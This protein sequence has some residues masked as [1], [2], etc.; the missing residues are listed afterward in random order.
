MEQSFERAYEILK[1]RCS[2]ISITKTNSAIEIIKGLNLD[3]DSIV[4]AC[5]YIPFTHNH[6]E[7]QEVEELFGEGVYQMV[8]AL[9]Q[10]HKIQYNNEQEEAENIRKMYFALAKDIRVIFIKLAFEVADMR[11][12]QLFKAD[13]LKAKAKVNLDLFAPL[14]ARLGASTIKSELEDVSFKLLH[15]QKY[16]EIENAVEKK[17]EQAQEMISALKVTLR[18]ILGQ[19]N[20]TGEIMGR[21]KHAYSIYKKIVNK[22]EG[23]NDIYDLVALRVIVEELPSCYAVLG[24]I[25][26]IFTPISGRFKDYIATPKSNGYQSLHTT[27]LY[28]HLPVEIQIRTF[29]MHRFA[30]FGYAAHWIYKEKRKQDSLDVKLG[31]VR[32]VIE[33]NESLSS[34]EM[35]GTLKV[36]IYDGEIFVQTPHGKVVHLPEGATPIDFAYAVHSEIGNRMTGVKINNKIQPITTKLQNGDVVEVITSP[37]SKGPSRDWLK[38]AKSVSTKH[39][40]RQ[41]FKKEMKE[42]NIKIGKSMIEIACKNQNLNLS[43]IIEGPEF[44]KM[45]VKY[46]FADAIELFAS[47]GGGSTSANNVVGY[48]QQVF[49]QQQK[50]L[51][52]LNA[53]SFSKT[54][55]ER[56]V[57]VEGADNI[58]VKF[59]NCCH[60]IP[61][62]EIVGFISQGRGLIVHR[63]NCEH[64]KYYDQNRLMNVDWKKTSSMQ[65]E[66]SVCAVVKNKE[67]ALPKITQV[68]A[69]LKL[70]LISLIVE[71]HTKGQSVIT[72]SV[73]LGGQQELAVLIKTLEQVEGVDEA[74]RK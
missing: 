67:T 51:D 21:R 64:V 32:R 35:I 37:H 52:R 54:K 34:D 36:D 39:K 27:I 5:L 71:N 13:V 26:E 60:P 29:D 23:I 22:K 4:A 9:S 10:L 72:I 45:L 44:K 3:N 24:K 40:I 68:I 33:E 7:K 47:V 70:S 57:E 43:D 42:E 6:I 38:V 69:D 16:K 62:D 46:S 1:A 28:E 30:E 31:W 56:A 53:K 73:G 12:P 14:A 19:L 18:D 15:P 55:T 25:H 58:L 63:K 41:F 61:N 20:I 11:N 50:M 49:K 48:I 66:A 59:A 74:F 65:F 2:E 8:H 17:F